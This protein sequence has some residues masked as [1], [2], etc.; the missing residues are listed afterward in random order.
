MRIEE[1]RTRLTDAGFRFVSGRPFGMD[2][3]KN[4]EYWVRERTNETIYLVYNKRGSY[5]WK[6]LGDIGIDVIWRKPEAEPGKGNT[7]CSNSK[8]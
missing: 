7:T 3:F 4:I 1:V 8:Y 2:N 5:H 6:L